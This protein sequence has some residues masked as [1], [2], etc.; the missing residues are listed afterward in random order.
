[1]EEKGFNFDRY[2]SLMRRSER[3]R[4]YLAAQATAERAGHKI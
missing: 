1:M 2:Q 4:R 3:Y